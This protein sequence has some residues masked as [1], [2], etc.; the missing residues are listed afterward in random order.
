[1]RYLTATPDIFTALSTSGESRDALLQVQDT[2]LLSTQSASSLP[3]QQIASDLG[4]TTS[5]P[6]LRIAVQVDEER[7]TTRLLEFLDDAMSA[8]TSGLEHSV[9]YFTGL[10]HQYYHVTRDNTL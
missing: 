8:E 5:D 9:Q 10:I 3:T 4:I 2:R 6:R 1:V 7:I